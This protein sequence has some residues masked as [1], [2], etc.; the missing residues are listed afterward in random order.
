MVS[1]LI[2]PTLACWREEVVRQ[3]FVS[4]NAEAIL[5]IPLCTR[6]VDDFWAWSGDPKGRFSV[7]SA[8][9]LI[10]KMKM[11]REDWLDEAEEMSS[12][13]SKG[14][15][16]IWGL[17]VPSKLKIFTWRLARHSLPT[18]DVLH[19]R[20]MLPSHVCALCGAADN[21]RHS[22]IDCNYARCV[23]ALS[24]EDMVQHM[25]MQ[26]DDQAKRWIFLTS[27]S[28]SQEEFTT[29]IVTL[30]AIW[31]ARRKIIHEGIYRTPFST[32]GF[33]T[34]YLADLKQ[35]QK[36]VDRP[37]TTPRARPT[38]QPPPDDHV[39][40]NVDAAVPRAGGRGAV[41]AV[42][43]DASGVFLGASAVIVNNIEDPEVLEV[44][45]TR[46]ALALADDLYE[47]KVFIASDCMA[48]V[49]AIKG[50]TAAAYGNNG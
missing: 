13:E 43:R 27:E 18:S 22:L 10:H 46:E 16:S 37:P 42:C 14:W 5:K 33:V 4:A 6:H 25:C 49:E 23:W 17:Q 48:A 32:N 50:G 26:R 30:W 3:V 21:W 41:G 29:M 7:K 35:I 1:D 45:A 40:I 11:G 31:A 2:E 28:L 24:N 15:S 8:Y 36:P 47:H 20:N 12:G 19:R 38:R 39:K 9:K 44:L 34:S